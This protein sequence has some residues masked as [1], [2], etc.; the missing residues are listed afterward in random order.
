[1]DFFNTHSIFFTVLGYPMSYLEFFAVVT[2]VLS[3]ILS[4]KA[5][6]WSWPVGIVNVF[7]SAF[8][9]YQIQL[10]PDMFLM[11][12]FFV[13]NILGWW[14]WANP[15]PEEED[16]RKELKV[17]FMPRKQFY[18]WLAVG[19]AG[20]ILI[21]ALASQLHNWFPLLFNLPSAYPFV[22]SFILVM[23]VITTFLMIQ[24]R[25][26]CWIIWLMIDIVATYLYFL[27]GA[28]FFGVE[29]IVFTI[30]AAFALW[31]WIKEYKSYDKAA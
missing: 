1:M 30:I 9:Y 24:K 5:S 13:T 19:I 8:F 25:I 20:T 11:A 17:S 4:A 15:K 2:G 3:V 26:E 12:F 21:G 18:T 29:Y 6:I 23:S 28:M 27:K 22:D 31:N 7:L 16:K 10:Y 14:R